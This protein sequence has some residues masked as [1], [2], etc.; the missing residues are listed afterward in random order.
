MAQV[1]GTKR[2]IP[3]FTGG[4][5]RSGTTIIGDLLGKHELIRTSTPT[6]IKFVSNAG[7]LLDVLFG[8]RVEPGKELKKISILN[9]RT[10]TKRKNQEIKRSQE[11]L[12][13]LEVMIWNKWWDIDAAPPHGRGLQSGIDRVKL[14]S[15]LSQFKSSFSKN[16]LKAGRNFLEG[17]ISQ[18]RHASAE[19]Y[20]VET[21][22]LNIANAERILKIFPDALFI[23]MVRDPRD[24]IASL[25]TKNWGPATPLEGIAWI[26]KRLIDGHRGLSNVPA[27]QQI[28]IALEDLVITNREGEYQRL[29]NFLQIN[30]SADMRMFFNDAMNAQDASSGRWRSEIIEPTFATEFDL[31][32]ERLTSQGIPTYVSNSTN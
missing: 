4:T 7:G 5:G 6:E 12:A 14:E 17:L 8:Y 1:S 18:Q 3:V 30:D 31:M 16:R 28:T 9:Y 2:P 27:P 10:Y 22:P 24:V 20:W 23:N 32:L 29:L 25:L 19:K 26:E 13:E 21:T 11:M 15:L